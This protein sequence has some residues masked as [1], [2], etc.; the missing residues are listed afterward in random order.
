MQLA[1]KLGQAATSVVMQ[2]ESCK[3]NRKVG[4]NLKVAKVTWRLKIER[5]LWWKKTAGVVHQ[6]SVNTASQKLG[7]NCNIGH[8]AIGKLQI[9]LES[10]K[11]DLEVKNQ[12]CIL[13][14][15]ANWF[16]L[17][18]LNEWSQLK[19]WGKLQHQSWCNRKAAKSTGKL[20]KWPESQKRNLEAQTRF[21]MTRWEFNGKETPQ[22]V[23]WNTPK[24]RNNARSSQGH[25]CSNLRVSF[26][27]PG[28]WH[29]QVPQS[30]LEVVLEWR[31]VTWIFKTSKTRRLPT[32]TG[33]ARWHIR[34]ANRSNNS[35]S[36]ILKIQTRWWLGAPLDAPWKNKTVA[37]GGLN[38]AGKRAKAIETVVG[39][40]VSFPIRPLVQPP[41]WRNRG[42]RLGAAGWFS[43]RS[44]LKPILDL[45]SIRALKQLLR[46]I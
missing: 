8:D 16:D 38:D 9:R 46:F 2:P 18:A 40:C 23:E 15:K 36:K 45:E 37:Q 10:C 4:S 17:P 13:M 6:L 20:Q 27:K 41:G 31:A 11:R 29:I 22:M 12:R 34:V 33:W 32:C 44:A 21:A 30:N 5:V 25:N 39:C 42:S 35:V 28:G 1:K 7:A 26:G 43:G 24:R 14:K 19:T 3:S